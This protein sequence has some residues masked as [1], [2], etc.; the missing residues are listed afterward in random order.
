[1]SQAQYDL[2]VMMELQQ[3]DLVN[4]LNEMFAEDTS[5]PDTSNDIFLAQLNHYGDK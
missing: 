2:E 3:E 1:M 4:T 5:F